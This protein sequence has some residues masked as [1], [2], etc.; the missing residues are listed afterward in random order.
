M[1]IIEVMK[2]RTAIL[3]LV[4][5][6][7]GLLLRLPLLTG[8]FWLDEAAQALESA[9]PWHQQLNI[10]QDFQP[11]LLHLLVFGAIRLSTA[12]WWLRLWGAVIPGL[13][14]ILLTYFIGKKIAGHRAGLIASLLLTTSSFHIFYSQELR[15]YSLPTFFAVG[16]WLFLLKLTDSKNNLARSWLGYV[17]MTI[18]GLYSS[19][20]YPFLLIG[21]AFYVFWHKRIRLQSWLS[22][23]LVSG[24]TWLP[25]L[26]FFLEQ[27]SVGQDVRVQL[28]GWEKVVST[29]QLMTLL[30]VI[31]KFLFGVV[32]IDVNMYFVAATLVVGLLLT[33]L[34]ITYRHVLSSKRSLLPF[35]VSWL[36]VPLATAWFISFVVPVVSPKRV[37]YLLP[38][39]YLLVGYLAS[40]NDLKITSKKV[41]IYLSRLLVGVLL[42]LNTIGTVQYFTNPQYQRENWRSLHNRII[43]EYPQQNSI[44]VFV[45]SEPFAPWVWYDD[46]SYPTLATGTLFIKDVTDLTQQLKPIAD[47]EYVLLFDYLRDLTDPDDL[48]IAQLK[49]FGYTERTVIDYPQI[50]FVRVYSRYQPIAIG[51]EL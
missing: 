24:I 37:M 8:S 45:F 15:P 1:V 12:E 17:L 11:P 41:T 25:W 40:L 36:V 20:L 22:A 31:G 47:Y 43:A 4:V 29:P 42:V 44:T 9:R 30:L 26:P 5:L 10:A 2:Y 32:N 50:G 13:G 39:F 48:I 16:S 46:G 19:Y 7:I 18:A 23:V 49:A 38:A 28:P 51:N 35:F 33:L 21:Q 14:T 34:F 6:L 27:L 3:V